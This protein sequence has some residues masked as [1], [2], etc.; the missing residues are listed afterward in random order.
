MGRTACSTETTSTRSTSHADPN[1]FFESPD[2]RGS[3]PAFSHT[4]HSR[5]RPTGERL[6][7]T[8]DLD[9]PGAVQPPSAAERAPAWCQH[10]ARPSTELRRHPG[11]ELL[12]TSPAGPRYPRWIGQPIELRCRGLIDTRAPSEKATSTTVRGATSKAN[13]NVI[14]DRRPRGIPTEPRP[15][16]FRSGRTTPRL[17]ATRIGPQDWMPA[18]GTTAGPASLC[19]ADRP[20]LSAAQHHPRQSGIPVLQDQGWTEMPLRRR[21]PTIGRGLEA[22]SAMSFCGGG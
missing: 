4:Q 14:Y 15:V 5:L 12:S 20:V 19:P 3:D 2:P 6:P 1:S 8:L 10:L 22:A 9:L 17:T 16:P 13:M 18:P 21:N 11:L 7:A